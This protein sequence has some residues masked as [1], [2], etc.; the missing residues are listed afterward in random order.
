MSNTKESLD[1]LYKM[2]VDPQIEFTLTPKNTMKT[3][4][5]MYKV[6][7]V[8]IKPASWQDMFFPNVHNRPGS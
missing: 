5:F 7:T 4:E 8:K 1:E 2:M 6:G 3:A